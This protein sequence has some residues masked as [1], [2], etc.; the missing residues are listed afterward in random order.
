MVES[1]FGHE[2]GTMNCC[3][4]ENAKL[5]V[6]PVKNGAAEGVFFCA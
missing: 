2:S 1:G 5:G 4:A 3:R 6:P